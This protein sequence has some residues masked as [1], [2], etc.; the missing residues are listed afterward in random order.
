MWYNPRVGSRP[1]QGERGHMGQ[2]SKER[3]SWDDY[4]TNITFV[5]ASRSS[6]IRRQV[7][8]L[9]VMEHRIISTGYNG[10]PFGVPN[11]NEGG[12]PRC[13]SAVASLEGYDWCLCVHAEQN[14]IALA[15]RQGTSTNGAEVYCTHRPC[16]GCLKELIQAGIRRVTYAEEMTYA[17][18]LEAVYVSLEQNSHIKLRSYP[19]PKLLA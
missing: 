4:Y 5:V 14:A 8:A 11:C 7:G 18:D 13:N 6:C 2:I 19:R 15:A 3:P 17:D 9:I 16:F 1:K 12:C 10:T